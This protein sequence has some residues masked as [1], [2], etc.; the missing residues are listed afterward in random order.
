MALTK[1]TAKS[2]KDDAITTE[3]I[4]HATITNIN[5]AQDSCTKDK[6]ADEAVDEA[7]LQVSNA[8]TNGQFLSKQSGNT[9][10]LTW[11][12]GASEGTEVKSTGE[13]GTT[14]FLRV[15]GDGTS[16]WQ[17][18]PDTVYTHPNHSGEV[19][20]TGDGATVIASNVV[21]EDN[22]KVSNTP[23]NG[24]VLSAQ[25][26]NTGG[27]TWTTISAAPQITG[28]A[29]GAI[30]DTA[31]VIIKSDGN[32]ASVVG[33]SASL[34][35]ETAINS[36]TSSY[37]FE[38]VFDSTNNK[39]VISNYGDGADFHT[40]VGTVSGTSISWGSMVEISNSLNENGTCIYCEHNDSI[41]Y[42]WTLGNSNRDL[43]CRVGEVSGTAISLSSGGET[44]IAN[45]S[46][47]GQYPKIYPNLAY[48]ESTDKVICF[49]ISGTKL[50]YSIGTFS[51]SA[52]ALTVSWS[53]GAY[54]YNGSTSSNGIPAADNVNN[55]IF[56]VWRKDVSGG[57]GIITC[58]TISSNT[59]TYAS[60]VTFTST[61]DNIL[62]PSVTY[63]PQ[64]DKV[65]ILWQAS[66]G[67]I[68]YAV[69]Q[70]AG[71]STTVSVGSEGT[72]YSGTDAEWPR[73]CYDSTNGKITVR[74]SV[75]TG[76]DVLYLLQGN[77]GS[78]NTITWE[79]AQTYN[80]GSRMA[81]G[82]VAHD[83]NA[84]KIV[85]AF[86]DDGD[87]GHANSLVWSPASTNIDS[88]NFVGFADGAVSNGQ[89]ATVNVAG[90]TV[91]KS[92]LTPGKKH[93]IQNDGS[94]ST[95]AATPSVEAG[96][97]LSSTKLLIK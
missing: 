22:L 14:K 85:T 31:A 83:S 94:L 21:D 63:S 97:A 48:S 64:D 7:R 12:D 88:E 13:S 54:V 80:N 35:S 39:V 73:A 46:A 26:G 71:S 78:G 34:G 86:R 29:S 82:S 41:V 37:P 30:A 36:D 84:G 69:G 19:T 60:D 62:Y 57:Q 16:S 45:S 5:L 87:S 77:F 58:G 67:N 90:N 20:S 52:G 33:T 81:F 6:I 65:L 66:N 95:T 4:A 8:G 1:I 42:A 40:Y 74:Y 3:Q 59:F 27:L 76:S 11:S 44:E 18:P 72:L 68:K 32:L 75:T 38:I 2:V 28:T 55:K 24:Q 25:S 10:G 43:G 15:D 93:Y 50:L 79:T 23:T 9:G 70:A 17:V 56:H 53:S 49:Y 51:G 92:S 96:I 89:T 61:N 47:A 91:T